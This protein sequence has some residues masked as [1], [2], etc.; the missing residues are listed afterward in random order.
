[1][2]TY[3]IVKNTDRGRLKV[4]TILKGLIG[5]LEE[6]KVLAFLIEHTLN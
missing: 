1:M 4:I 5:R 6:K 3:E 2:E